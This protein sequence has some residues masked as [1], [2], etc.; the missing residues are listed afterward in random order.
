MVHKFI[1]VY[2]QALYFFST[3]VAPQLLIAQVEMQQSFSYAAPHFY[4]EALNFRSS[5]G[6]SRLDFYFQMPNDEIQFVKYGSEFKASYEISLRLTDSDGNPALEQTWTE[7][8]NC[9]SFDETTSRGI[10][11]S[12]QRQ[13]IVQPGKYSLQVVVTDSET[14]RSYNA[15]REFTARNYSDSS[16]CSMSDIMLLNASSEISGKRTIMPNINGNVESVK[17]SF[18]VFYEIYFPNRADSVFAATELS[19]Y[20]GKI[21]YSSSSWLR[22][23]QRTES[24]VNEIPKDSLPMGF[25]ELS[26]TLRDSSS[27]G[28]PV[29]AKASC[30]FSNHF[31]ELPL[32]ITDL[33][34]AA[35]ELMYIAKG[36]TIDSIKDAPNDFEKEKLFLHFW[37]KYNTNPSSSRNPLMYEYYDRV[38]Y[39]N[40]HFG[41]Y[42]AGWKSDMGM[43]YILYGPPN[44]VD[45][46]PF[47]INSKPYEVWYYYQRN[48]N[49]VF[50]DQTGFGDYR[51]INPLSDLNSTPYGPDFVPR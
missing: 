39:A 37:Q 17:D 21:F 29:V 43:I 26:V 32:T 18:P 11:S 40:K 8:P 12:V 6:K 51:L 44:S 1:P 4:F 22:N 31:P 42:F 28:A 27:K 15:E 10:S 30:Q 50:V 13:F 48:V 19:G 36:S 25:Y 33:N 24:I 14:Q 23:S 41:N 5:A 3:F 2:L 34:K 38:A 20:K 45:R 35:D 16:S 9:Q 46:H 7:R 47:E 49:F